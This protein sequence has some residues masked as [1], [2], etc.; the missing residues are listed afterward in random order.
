MKRERFTFIGGNSNK[1]YTV[2][3]D[4]SSPGRFIAR[5]E[6]G[7][8]GGNM[9]TVVKYDGASKYQAEQAYSEE[10]GNRK[11]KGYQ[12]APLGKPLVES[13]AAPGAKDDFVPVKKGESPFFNMTPPKSDFIF[14]QLLNEISEAELDGYLDSPEWI[15]QLKK[16]GIRFQLVRKGQTVYGYRG[17]LGTKQTALPEDVV[18]AALRMNWDN[19]VLDGELVGDLFWAFDVLSVNGES[20]AKMPYAQRYALL[21][22]WAESEYQGDGISVVGT[23]YTRSQ[24]RAL[25]T[26]SQESN[27]EGV[28]FKKH[29]AA[30][31]AGRP[32]KLGD[33]LK[34]KFWVTAS[35][36]VAGVN[37]KGKSSFDMKLFDGTPLGSCTV[38]PNKKMPS[39]GSAVEVAYLYFVSSLVQPEFIS[40]RYSAGRVH[41]F[42]AEEETGRRV[43]PEF[44]GI[45]ASSVSGF[46]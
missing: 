22:G 39:V 32:N 31:S 7:R 3:L 33:W 12:P 42:T 23:A 37:A 40:V 1:E 25:L 21:E 15:M 35:V 4:D 2:V 45:K 29:A 8:I 43:M 46:R 30:Y 41:G 16:D 38:P 17:K 13:K 24:K 11:R 19:F 34:Y 28:V 36:I 6:Y 18:A 9:V 5:G 20:V 27:A 14:P 10:I 26:A 44:S